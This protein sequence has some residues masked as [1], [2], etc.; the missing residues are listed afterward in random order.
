MGGHKKKNKHRTRGTYNRRKNHT[1]DKLGIIIVTYNIADLITKQIECIKKFCVDKNYDIIIIENSDHDDVSTAIR[2]YVR[3]IDCI[4][5]KTRSADAN[6]SLSHAFACNFAYSKF[7][8]NYDL[9]LFLDH[10]NF[11]IKNFSVAEILKDKVIAGLGQSKSKDY[12]WPGCVMFNNSSIEH[13]LIDFSVSHDLELDTGGML[14]KIIERHGKEN[15]AFF[16][17][18]YYENPFW[19]SVGYNFYATINNDMFMHFINSSNWNPTDKNKERI[20]T[21]L[22]ILDGKIS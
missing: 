7:R 22:H 15:C 21:L 11:P 13:N 9:F 20:Y 17:E 8:D 1:M 12:Y 16:D 6:S 2:Y 10:D 18:K 4:F 5:L 3:N 19:K 14:Y